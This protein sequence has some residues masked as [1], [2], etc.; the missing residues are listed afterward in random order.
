MIL[1]KSKKSH[2][3]VLSS[4]STASM[5]GIAKRAM[6]NIGSELIFIEKAYKICYELY[7]AGISINIQFAFLSLLFAVL[8]IKTGEKL[9]DIQGQCRIG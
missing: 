1:N 5:N 9:G 8:R 4:A 6:K 3:P 7:F 2:N